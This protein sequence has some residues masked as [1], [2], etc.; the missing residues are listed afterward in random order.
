MLKILYN[1][2]E[3]KEIA[4]HDIDKRNRRMVEEGC[5]PELQTTPIQKPVA[6]KVTVNQPKTRK[7][8]CVFCK[9]DYYSTKCQVYKTLDQRKKKVYKLDLCSRCLRIGH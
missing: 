7:T 8:P 2:I 9:G 1:I 4:G 6:Y 5:S 3:A